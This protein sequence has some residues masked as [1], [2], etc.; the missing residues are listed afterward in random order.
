MKQFLTCEPRESLYKFL[1]PRIGLAWSSDFHAIGRVVDGTLVGVV[2][3][4]GFTGSCCQMHMAGDTKHWITREFLLQAFRYPF[5]TCGLNLVLAVVPS[6]NLQALEIDRKLG[7]EE[8]L[9]LPR[10]HPDGGLHF[11]KMTR[12]QCRWVRS[13]S[14]G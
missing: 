4:N 10:A 1:A 7:F 2:G 13:D 8:I 14:D 5:V 11:L 9:Y 12:E 3:Y 6:G